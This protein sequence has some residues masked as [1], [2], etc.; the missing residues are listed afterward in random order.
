VLLK[1]LELDSNGV[2]GNWM[3]QPPVAPAPGQFGISDILRFAQ[4]VPSGA[5]PAPALGQNAGPQP[6][7]T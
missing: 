4:V 7:V 3:P 1:L 5:D 2:P 6:P